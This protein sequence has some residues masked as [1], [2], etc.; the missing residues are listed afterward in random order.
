MYIQFYKNNKK[1]FLKDKVS[2]QGLIEIPNEYLLG[3]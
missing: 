1:A 2:I 3:K